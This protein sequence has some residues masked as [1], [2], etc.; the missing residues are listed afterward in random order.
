MNP[1]EIEKLL[2]GYATDTLTEE[3]RSTLFAAAMDNQALFDALADEQALRDLLQDPA[4]RAQLRAAL[5]EDRLSLGARITAW[6]R[7]PSVLA[8]AGAVA[9]G[10][11]LI[12]VAPPGKRAL[13]TARPAMVAMSKPPQQ[14][15]VQAPAP[16]P[17]PTPQGAPESRVAKQ[18]ESKPPAPRQ[19]ITEDKKETD[20]EH[21]TLQA[22]N[23]PARGAAPKAEPVPAPPPPPATAPP[24]PQ[25]FVPPAQPMLSLRDANQAPPPGAQPKPADAAAE[26]TAAGTPAP[27][28]AMRKAAAPAAGAKDL[29]Y[30]GQ[31]QPANELA[32]QK[33]AKKSKAAGR[34]FSAGTAGGALGRNTTA[35]PKTAAA[36]FPGIRYSIQQRSADGGY[37][38]IDPAAPLGAGAA[39]RLRLEAN[40]EGALSVMRREPDGT[41]RPWGDAHLRAGQPAYLPADSPVTMPAPGELHFQVRFVP[42]AQPPIATDQVAASASPLRD[43]VGTSV[44][45]VNPRRTAGAGVEFEL[46]VKAQ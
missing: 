39:V 19:V 15:E 7:R 25:A 16:A 43:Q 11:V 23:A 29:Y 18:M 22:Q 40:Q 4:S 32:D 17:A 8:L 38:E 12:A 45:V 1:R 6:L 30:A 35:A 44:Y 2:G 5:G 21:E 36:P 9:A 31:P 14:P 27:A 37:V 3:E 34:G 28:A 26:S 13:E 24:Q 42:A 46:V 20:R 10:I 41:W 33:T